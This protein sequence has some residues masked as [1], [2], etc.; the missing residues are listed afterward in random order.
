VVYWEIQRQRENRKDGKE[1]GK[2]GGEKKRGKKGELG[3]SRTELITPSPLLR[4]PGQVI[5]QN[6]LAVLQIFLWFP[7]SP[8]VA[9]PL[10]QKHSCLVHHFMIHDGFYLVLLSI[11]SDDRLR[12][13]WHVPDLRIIGNKLLDPMNVHHW[14]RFHEIVWKCA[15][16]RCFR[17]NIDVIPM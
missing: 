5:S 2:S 16:H 14:V 3:K 4:S 12:W 9:F 1:G 11:C 13:R 17:C 6:V 10:N 7:R 8:L 15:K